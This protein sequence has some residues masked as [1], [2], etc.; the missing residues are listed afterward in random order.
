[1]APR[2]SRFEIYV[3]VLTEIN[4]GVN[5]PTKIMYGANMSWNTLM[6]TLEMLKAQG[7]IEEHT[8]DGNKRSRRRYTLTGKGNKVLSYLKKVKEILETEE[9]VEIPV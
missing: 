8:I 7:F 1:M 2:R 5:L 6:E 3:D 9:A 4:N